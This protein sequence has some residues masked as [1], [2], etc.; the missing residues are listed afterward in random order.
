VQP[1]DGR[2]DLFAN[3][4]AQDRVSAI[5]PLGGDHPARNVIRAQQ[6]A[7]CGSEH[8]KAEPRQLIRAKYRL[9]R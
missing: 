5:E 6:L 2:S 3:R 1:L 8:A 7:C 9:R 4:R